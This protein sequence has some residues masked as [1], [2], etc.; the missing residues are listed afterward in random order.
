[1]NDLVVS[2]QN[3]S[4]TYR[5]WRT[6]SQR[7][8]SPLYSRLAQAVGGTARARLQRKAQ[9][10]YQDFFALHNVSFEV[11]RG[12]ALG[13]V[14]RNG[15]GK[16]TLLQIIAGTT[17]P[18]SGRLEVRGR[19]AALLELGAGFNPEFTG[20]ENIRLNA[21]VLGLDERRLDERMD[22]IIAYADIGEF[23]DQ[24]VRTY[25]TGMQMRVAFAVAAHVD[26][27]VLIIDEALGVGDA[28]FQLKCAKTIDGFVEAGKTLLFVS[29]DPSS[30]KRLCQRAVLLEQGRALL[31]DEPNFV[32]NFYSKLLAEPAPLEQLEKEAGR[33][34]ALKRERDGAVAPPAGPPSSRPAEP[35]PAAPPP[36]DP[37]PLT[38]PSASE[39]SRELGRQ[40][41]QA[42][43]TIARLA[44][45][46]PLRQKAHLVAEADRL[47]PA[48]AR[49]KEFSYGG[50]LGRIDDLRIRDAAGR[51]NLVFTTGDRITVSFQASAR[52]DISEPLYALTVKSVV[53][54][55][56]YVTNTFYRGVAVGPLRA[57]GRHRV[58]FSLQ[59]NLMPG[60]YFISLG[61]VTFVGSELLVVHRRY[62]AVKF[63]VLP[64]DRRVG[65]ANL[66][67]EITV[68]PLS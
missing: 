20:R 30:V 48:E 58:D 25:S 12:E 2:V 18:T 47:E 42:H 39:A 61:F 54:Q 37:S 1:M 65:V 51:D 9:S 32:I 4:K 43:L 59:L 60:E 64:V 7:L 27:D 15:S 22:S 26:A 41:A 34:L 3:I 35:P 23:I 16:S 44:A 31:D 28:R 38:G 19:V 45:D 46:P 67:S 8:L 40:L 11:R 21:I 56:L 24:P 50:D 10:G 52:E 53:G 68:T 29:H 17:Q 49:G 14:G 13:I 33:A 62:D 55:D 57:G 5:I 36:P 63:Q 6:P 66:H